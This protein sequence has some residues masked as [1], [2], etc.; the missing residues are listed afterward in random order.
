MLTELIQISRRT[1]VRADEVCSVA[2]YRDSIVDH[3]EGVP[4][5]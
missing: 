5:V 2:D 1:S 3:P 4:I